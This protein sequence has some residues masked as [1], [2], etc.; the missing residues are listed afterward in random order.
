MGTSSLAAKLKIKPG[1]RVLVLNAP[2]KVVEALLPL[3]D[4]AEMVTPKAKGVDFGMLFAKDTAELGKRAAQLIAA[5][6]PD[7][8]VWVCYPKKTSKIHTDLSRDHGWEPVT[9]EG[10]EGVALIALDDDWSAMRFRPGLG[11]HRGAGGPD[12]ADAALVDAMFAGK[13][14]ALR[15]IYEKLL[16][17]GKG[18]GSDVRIAP[19]KTYVPLYRRY[20]FAQIKPTTGSRVDLMLCLRDVPARGRLLSTGGLGKGDRM[21]HRI[22]IDAPEDVDD[23]VKRWYAEAY[24]RGV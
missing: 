14:A 19:T 24:K 9:R 11:A 8:L 16:K 4:G 17:V 5:V 20:Q 18:L 22:A 12:T 2:A 21:T 3:P 10:L 23:E 7:G 1:H 15:P 6:K 13:K